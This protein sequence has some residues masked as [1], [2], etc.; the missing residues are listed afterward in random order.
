VRR[1]GAG[2][3]LDDEVSV[4]ADALGARE[5]RVALV[6]MTPASLDEGDLRVAEVGDGLPQEVRSRHEVRVEDGDELA[7][8]PLE[9]VLQGPGL[10]A[11]ARVPADVPDVEA[12]LPVSLDGL[13]RDPDGLVVGIVEDLD[14]EPVA[15]VVQRRHGPEQPL[16]HVAFVEDRQL[17]R[18]RRDLGRGELLP[19]VLGDGARLLP[20]AA[21]GAEEG[22]HEVVAVDPVDEQTRRTEQI[23]TENNETQS[24]L[25][26]SPFTARPRRS[27]ESSSG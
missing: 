21:A 19:V 3:L 5:E 1:V 6:Q 24:V 14:L 12:L 8:S 2:V 27:P 26:V 15:G 25:L 18:D 10:E 7:A 11:D 13:G 22:R 4:D 16:D 20:G 9:P 17:D 23:Q